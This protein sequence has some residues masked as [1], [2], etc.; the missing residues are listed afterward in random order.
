MQYIMFSET[1]KM[2]KRVFELWKV[3]IKTPSEK[4]NFPS[5]WSFYDNNTI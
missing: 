4:M 2:I 5:I 1:E 3:S